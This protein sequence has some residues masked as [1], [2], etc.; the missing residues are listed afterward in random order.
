MNFEKNQILAPR[1]SIHKNRS[2][3]NYLKNI[4]LD[5]V[6]N[7][8]GKAPWPY[9]TQQNALSY[10]HG[11][12][13][14]AQLSR[15]YDYVIRDKPFQDFIGLIRLL[16]IQCENGDK[17]GKLGYWVTKIPRKKGYAREALEKIINITLLLGLKEVWASC[18]KDNISSS[19]LL[20]KTGLRL[21]GEDVGIYLGE[22]IKEYVYQKNILY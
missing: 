12:Q 2:N 14:A 11:C 8:G 17:P 3:E 19:R 22:Y 6:K 5:V 15:C 13:Q 20:Q 21:F 16:A 4:D 9:N 7:I 18:R 1:S 10:V